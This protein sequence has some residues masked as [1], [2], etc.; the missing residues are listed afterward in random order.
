MEI[1][2]KGKHAPQ[3]DESLFWQPSDAHDSQRQ[4]QLKKAKE[5][6]NVAEIADK[7]TNPPTLFSPAATLAN[8]GVA[9]AQHAKK[10]PAADVEAQIDAIVTGPVRIATA[11]RLNEQIE[12]ARTSCAGKK[13]KRQKETFFLPGRRRSKQAHIGVPRFHH[14]VMGHDSFSSYVSLHHLACPSPLKSSQSTT[15][16]KKSRSKGLGKIR[17]TNARTANGLRSSAATT[18][19]FALYASFSRPLSSPSPTLDPSLPQPPQQPDIE[20]VRASRDSTLDVHVKK[21]DLAPFDVKFFVRNERGHFHFDPTACDHN[22]AG[23]GVDGIVFHPVPYLRRLVQL[24]HMPKVAS[25]ATPFRHASL[26]KAIQ[27]VIEAVDGVPP[28]KGADGFTTLA[29]QLKGLPMTF[30]PL[31]VFDDDSGPVTRGVVDWWWRELFDSALVAPGPGEERKEWKAVEVEAIG[32]DG[33]PLE[34]REMLEVWLVMGRTSDGSY[35]RSSKGVLG[36]NAAR[37]SPSALCSSFL[38][39]RLRN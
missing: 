10:M 7:R 24:I 12:Q 23:N 18:T 15:S 27:L 29:L 30:H 35:S 19:L 21:F 32:D 5:I 25:L 22:P 6:V 16:Q 13:K 37:P 38:S 8:L 17:R 1:H 36:A 11:K 20:L 39:R 9:L 34:P 3:P 4:K 33:E 28:A 14:F 31:L 26:G 2:F